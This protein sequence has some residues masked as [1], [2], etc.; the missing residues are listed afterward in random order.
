M[1]T[2]HIGM[3]DRER[4]FWRKEFAIL[5]SRYQAMQ[6]ASQELVQALDLEFKKSVRDI[7]TDDIVGV[8]EFYPTLREIL[9]TVGMNYPT[10]LF[11]VMDDES[12]G[13]GIEDLFE[14]ASR[15][16]LEITNGKDHAT[17]AL[18]DALFC[19]VGKIGIDYNPPGDDIIAPWTANSENEEDMISFNRR[20]P[21]AVHIDPMVPPHMVGHARYVREKILIP[22]KYLRDDKSIKH[23]KDIRPMGQPDDR[24]ALWGVGDLMYEQA[25]GDDQQAVQDAML[26]GEFVLCDRVHVKTH[27]PGYN[28]RDPRRMIMFAPGVEEPIKN[29]PH[30]FMKRNFQQRMNSMDEPMFDP[31]TEEPVLDLM[32]EADDGLTGAPGRGWLVKHG[33]PFVF[34][35]IDQ[36]PTSFYPEAHFRYLKDIQEGIIES[37]TRSADMQKRGSRIVLVKESEKDGDSGDEV[38]KPIGVAEDGERIFVPNPENW[39]PFEW[40]G[41]P[42]KGQNDYMDR[43]RGLGQRISQMRQIAEKGG[44]TATQAALLG[45]AAEVNEQWG[46]AAMSGVYIDMVRNGFTVMGD[47]R[48]TPE[49]FKANVAPDGEQ[50]L[51]RVLRFSDFLWTYRITAR[52]GSMQPMFEQMQQDRFLAFYDRAKADQ[53]FD[54]R[55]LAKLLAETF[56]RDPEK[57]LV[58]DANP[59]E[60]R[61][62]QLENDR[63]ITQMQDP[64]VIMEQDHA[65]QIPI[66]E[67]YRE[68][69]S[70]QQLAQ[71]AQATDL[72][73][74]SAD[75]QA[76]LLIQQIDQ[77]MEGHI[78]AHY[79]AEEQKQSNLGGAAPAS[80]DSPQGIVGQVRSNAGQLAD[81]AQISAVEATT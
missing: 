66:H 34:V 3:S 59:A 28:G 71:R 21:F 44:M 69:P 63:I 48:F 42:L 15:N 12:Q 9:A 77:V 18:I 22:L 36:H 24:G 38:G 1:T 68:H 43:L 13:E 35:K 52:A 62:A 41:E 54:Q 60:Q 74:R 5:E 26:N 81:A 73:G 72:E 67:G 75:P 70:Y 2:K 16:L 50:R 53:M 61:A 55:E 20:P 39:H 45:A 23:R 78:A 47:P 31:E 30:P 37:I 79:E 76:M 19:R 40:A 64:G 25:P 57:L 4:E 7:P 29:V 8:S 27:V 58:Q 46:E 6:Q 11:E 80:G 33:F 49:N 32:T 51:T 10:L 56:D 17:Q 65:A 14:R